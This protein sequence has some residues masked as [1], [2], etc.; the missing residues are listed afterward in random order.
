VEYR[1]G[2]ILATD[3]PFAESDAREA[4]LSKYLRAFET[5]LVAARH[6]PRE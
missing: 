1:H 2:V 4:K 5:V 6:A 3:T